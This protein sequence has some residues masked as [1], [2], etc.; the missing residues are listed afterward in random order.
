MESAAILE[1][2]HDVFELLNA[3]QHMLE[4][5][6]W[7]SS[8]AGMFTQQGRNWDFV[9][10]RLASLADSLTAQA[11]NRPVKDVSERLHQL[12]R[13]PHS[14]LV[15]QEMDRRRSQAEDVKPA[16]ESLG[17]VQ[18]DLLEIEKLL[19]PEAAAARERLRTQVPPIGE[20]MRQ[21]ADRAGKEEAESRQ[22]AAQA[23]AV[24][25]AETQPA[26]IKQRAEHQ[27]WTAELQRIMDTLR[28]LANLRNPLDPQQ[29]ELAHD[30]DDAT[31][32]LRPP[33]GPLTARS[34]KP[35]KRPRPS[36]RRTCSRRPQTSSSIL[37]QRCHSWRITLSGLWRVKT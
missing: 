25:P 6:K 9:I 22:L 12:A 34:S 37:P 1:T 27:Q 18:R 30:V 21:L 11:P 2:G 15:S 8:S 16:L 14:L 32:M 29:G 10:D 3:V 35:H 7:F 19:R 31:A 23:P 17:L 36:P 28:R 33:R 13:A 20:Q 4:N 26:A 24:N 5:E